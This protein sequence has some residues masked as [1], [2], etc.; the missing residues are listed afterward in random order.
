VFSTAHVERMVGVVD[1]QTAAVGCPLLDVAYF[2][3][4]GLV[5]EVRRPCEEE[6]VGDYVAQL[7]PFGVSLSID[8]GWSLYRRY[9][10]A[11]FVMAVVAS[12]IVKQTD[13]GDEMFLAMA[14]R[15]A[16]HVVDLEAFGA[17]AD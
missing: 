5:A 14:N 4:A 13:R 7:A 10:F 8:E 1:F 6:L 17:L 15:H 12:M 11:G 16:Q 3:G 2:V 9:T